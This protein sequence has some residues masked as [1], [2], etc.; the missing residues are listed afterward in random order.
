MENSLRYIGAASP[1]V[2]NI[3]LKN[4]L[5]HLQTRLGY[6]KGETPSPLPKTFFLA[7][8]QLKQQKSKSRLDKR[9]RMCS[10]IT[11]ETIFMRSIKAIRYTRI[12]N[13]SCTSAKDETFFST[14][15]R[16]GY[17]LTYVIYPQM[18]I[19]DPDQRN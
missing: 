12:K 13:L 3:C 4:L 1:Q 5:I 2:L 18:I 9:Q 7:Q 8:N 11:I 14:T 16:H 19:R 6:S 15:V 17:L 10:Y